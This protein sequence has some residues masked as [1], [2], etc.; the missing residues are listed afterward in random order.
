MPNVICI[1]GEPDECDVTMSSYVQSNILTGPP[2]A[3]GQTPNTLLR[4]FA[5]PTAQPTTPQLYPMIWQDQNGTIWFVSAGST[6]WIILE[7]GV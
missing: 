7:Q 4:A 5:Y 2:G 1:Q 6:T 3:P